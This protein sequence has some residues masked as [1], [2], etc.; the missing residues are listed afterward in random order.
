M[1]WM[2]IDLTV[3]SGVCVNNRPNKEMKVVP[4]NSLN[5]KTT[6]SRT[7]IYDATDFRGMQ[8][9]KR[10]VQLRATLIWERITP[11]H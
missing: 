4:L 3:Q 11:S 10:I 1:R 9:I 5:C 7:R 2:P 6:R 8:T